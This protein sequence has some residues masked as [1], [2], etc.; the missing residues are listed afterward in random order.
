MRY[1]LAIYVFAQTEEKKWEGTTDCLIETRSML[2]EAGCIPE[3]RRG[4]SDAA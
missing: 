1:T 4:I 3:R 2:K